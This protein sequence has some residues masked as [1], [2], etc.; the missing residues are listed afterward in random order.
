MHFL[1]FRLQD[2]RTTVPFTKGL[3]IMVGLNRTEGRT[4]TAIVSE[5]RCVAPGHVTKQTPPSSL[6]DMFGKLALAFRP[7]FKGRC[8]ATRR[9]KP[10]IGLKHIIKSRCLPEHFSGLHRV[11]LLT[12]RVEEED[13]ILQ[14]F[15][16]WTSAN[17]TQPPGLRCWQ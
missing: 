9:G 12:R 10:K 8:V 4:V 6:A 16:L 3:V 14:S 17:K 5:A 1:T 13:A 7:Q 2:Y 15:S 11:L